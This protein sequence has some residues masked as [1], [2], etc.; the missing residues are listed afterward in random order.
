MLRYR[1]SESAIWQSIIGNTGN[2]YKD[3]HVIWKP[4]EIDRLEDDW[5]RDIYFAW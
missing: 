5:Q 1:K 3:I 2:I 4:S